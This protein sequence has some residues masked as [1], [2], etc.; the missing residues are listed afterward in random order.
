MKEFK[1]NM[2]VRLFQKDKTRKQQ[3]Q[4]TQNLPKL[5]SDEGEMLSVV[6]CTYIL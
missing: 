3:K 1:A 2:E 4:Q 5:R 6:L